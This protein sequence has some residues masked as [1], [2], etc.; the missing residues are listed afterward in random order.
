ML[1]KKIALAALA[2]SA[3]LATAP[4]IADGYRGDRQYQRGDQFQHPSRGERQFYRGERFQRHAVYVHNHGPRA[5]GP[6]R[7]IVQQP[8]VVHRPVAVYRDSRSHNV[9]GGLILGTI[10]GVAIAN[11]A[12]GGY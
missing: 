12:G 8:V 6:H 7:V 3:L 5:Y 2:G 1:M 10:I 9:L 4:A 11:H